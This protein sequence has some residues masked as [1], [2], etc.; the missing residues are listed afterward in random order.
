M[1]YPLKFKRQGGLKMQHVIDE[2]YK[3]TKG[4]A[5][6]S[7]D[8]GQ[9]QMWAAQF[10]KNESRYDWLSSGGAGTMGFG[11][12]LRLVRRLGGVMISYLFCGRWGFPND[13]FELATAAIHK[14]PVKIVVLNNH[15]LGMVR[16]WQGCSMMIV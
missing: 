6:V 11:F 9:H 14:L 1:A 12:Q 16:Q 2:F 15:Y 5:C 3:Q 13:V 4:R 8:V 10:Y 7:T